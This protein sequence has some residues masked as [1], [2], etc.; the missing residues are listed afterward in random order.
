MSHIAGQPFVQTERRI[1]K[2]VPTLME[3]WRL[4]CR[5]VALPTELIL[6]EANLGTAAGRTHNTVFPLRATGHEIVQAVLLIREIQD[7][8]LQA[9]RFSDGFRILQ[10]YVRIAD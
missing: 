9:F 7:R 5:V 8:L 10:V 6:E 2:M 1:P 4:G 3:N